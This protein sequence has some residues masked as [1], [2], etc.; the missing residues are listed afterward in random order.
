MRRVALVMALAAC[1]LDPQSVLSRVALRVHAFDLPEGGELRLNTT[2]SRPQTRTKKTK[3]RSPMMEILYE[4]GSLLPGPVT[5]SAEVFD[6]A[7]TLVGCGTA[8]GVAGED[9]TVIIGFASP[10]TS[11]LNC[12]ACGN[13]CETELASGVCTG[14]LCTGWECPPGL[15]AEADGG[16]H[17]PVVVIPDSGTPDAGSGDGGVPDGGGPDGGMMMMTD[18]GVD[19]GTDGGPPMCMPVNENTDVTCSDG[20]D[21]D[22]DMMTDCADLACRTLSRTCTTTCGTAGTQTWDCTTRTWSACAGDPFSEATMATCKDNIDNDCDGK[23]DCADDA[24]GN[25]EVPC[26]VDICAAGVKLWNCS[27]N[28]LGLTCLPHIPLPENNALLPLCNNG[29]DDDCDNK[30]DCADT[31]CLG[32]A[33]GGGKICCADGGCA[34]GC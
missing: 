17:D 24:C 29:L 1:T 8:R 7:G 9:M 16:C 15:V 23:K 3:V 32:R 11:A 10:S 19:G 18:G 5:L 12:G 34:T 27:L 22:C 26:G 28:L 14:G 31:Q 33:C 13:R 25:I 4:E 6:E 21:N 30:T 2:D 20:L